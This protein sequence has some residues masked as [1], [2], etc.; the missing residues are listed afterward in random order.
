MS[1]FAGAR[2]GLF[3]ESTFRAFVS[4]LE[5]RTD[6]PIIFSKEAISA[7]FWD[8]RQTSRRNAERVHRLQQGR[9]TRGIKTGDDSGQS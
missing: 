1:N 6:G 2:D 9:F 3:L 7:S 5:E 8:P 4:E